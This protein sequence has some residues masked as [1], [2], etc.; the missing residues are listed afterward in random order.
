MIWIILGFLLIFLIYAAVQGIRTSH[1][2]TKAYE[3]LSNYNVK[4]RLSP[5]AM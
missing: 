1:G 4:Q 5:M 2:L 3:R